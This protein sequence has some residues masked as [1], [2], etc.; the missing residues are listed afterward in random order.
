[1]TD[2]KTERD[3]RDRNRVSSNERNELFHFAQQNGITPEQV[4]ELIKAVGNDRA[5]LRLRR[6]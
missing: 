2:N 1:M 3:F 5:S 4:M 6:N